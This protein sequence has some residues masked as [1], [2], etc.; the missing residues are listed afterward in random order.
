MF[1][2]EDEVTMLLQNAAKHTPRD[3]VPHQTTPL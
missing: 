2:P 3:A 1:G